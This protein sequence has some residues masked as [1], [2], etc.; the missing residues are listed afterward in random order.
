MNEIR[1]RV[2]ESDLVTIEMKT[3]KGSQKREYID[4]SPWLYEG[5]VLKEKNLEII[6][7]IQTGTS[8]KTNLWLFIVPMK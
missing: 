4:I 7:K 3:F 2:A 1:N 5:I 6:L 8:I